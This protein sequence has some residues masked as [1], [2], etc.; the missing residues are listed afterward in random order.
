MSEKT[1]Y[2][3]H[4]M[5]SSYIGSFPHRQVTDTREARTGIQ[6]SN[7]SS[8]GGSFALFME[9]QERQREV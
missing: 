2:H 1:Q 9:Y 8:V 3:I 7:Q 6:D 4:N 5:L